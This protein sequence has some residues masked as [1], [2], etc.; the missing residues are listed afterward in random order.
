[1]AENQKQ[2]FV[3]FVAEMVLLLIY[4]SQGRDCQDIASSVVSRIESISRNLVD[5]D[6]QIRDEL[7]KYATVFVETFQEVVLQSKSF[8]LGQI[9]LIGNYSIVFYLFNSVWHFWLANIL[10][11]RQAFKKLP[12]IMRKLWP[13]VACWCPDTF[14]EQISEQSLK[15]L[16]IRGS[17]NFATARIIVLLNTLGEEVYSAIMMHIFPL[18]KEKFATIDYVSFF[19]ELTAVALETG[20]PEFQSLFTYFCLDERVNPRLLRKTDGKY[21]FLVTFKS[22][23]LSP[24]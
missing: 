20:R 9:K 12:D 21:S 24:G 14:T 18:M 19:V 3:F 1:M 15:L 22:T 6:L 23:S 7:R 13:F 2:K 10:R 5:A 11:H 16:V 4:V 17:K 8:A